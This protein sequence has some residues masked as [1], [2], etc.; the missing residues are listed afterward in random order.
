M[1]RLLVRIL[2]AELTAITFALTGW[3]RRAPEGFSMHRRTSFLAVVGVVVFLIA[4]ESVA[5]HLVLAS[6]SVT[7]AWIVTVLSI[8]GVIW[9]VGAAHAARLRPLRVTRDHVVVEK[10]LSWRVV[11][12]RASIVAVAPIEEKVPGALDL[13]YLSPNVL[14]TLADAVIARGPF[15]ITR[16]ASRITLSLDDRDRFLG[17]ISPVRATA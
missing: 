14:V 8:Y 2:T 13:S 6:V 5:A 1:H 12:P 7:A 16:S 4:V 9:V 11:V 3:F 17:T 15:G 10:G